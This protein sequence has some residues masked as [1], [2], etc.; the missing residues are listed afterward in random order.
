[1]EADASWMQAAQEATSLL[2]ERLCERMRL[3]R[4]LQ[5]RSLQVWNSK[6][7]ARRSATSE[8]QH[9]GTLRDCRCWQDAVAV[10]NRLPTDNNGDIIMLGRCT[11]SYLQQLTRRL[12]L[13]ILHPDSTSCSYFSVI[14]GLQ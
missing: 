5:R 8:A 3:Q 2:P 1:M 7:S 14:A 11:S 6:R 12:Q 4:K 10:T 13:C 9:L